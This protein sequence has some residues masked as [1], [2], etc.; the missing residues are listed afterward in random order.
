ML[1]TNFHSNNISISLTFLYCRA[2]YI[3][4]HEWD[5]KTEI[6][7]T[8][9]RR[10]EDEKKTSKRNE[11]KALLFLAINILK[12][13]SICTYKQHTPHLKMTDHNIMREKVNGS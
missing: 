1:L 8:V 4:V 7:L 11:N 13:T 12:V 9:D 5:R 2:N 10:F 6:N 3:F